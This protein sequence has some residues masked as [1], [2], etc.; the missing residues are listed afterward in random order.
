MC[1]KLLRGETHLDPLVMSSR[2][3]FTPSTDETELEMARRH[4]VEGGVLVERQ[5][6]VLAQLRAEGHAPELAERVLK[7]LKLAQHLHEQHVARL[8]GRDHSPD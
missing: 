2:F 1:L 6:R 4:V 3:P 7:E 5:E 8:S